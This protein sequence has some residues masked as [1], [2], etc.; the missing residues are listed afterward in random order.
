MAANLKPALSVATLTT[1]QTQ[2]I[3]SFANQLSSEQLLWTSGYLAGLAAKP[4]IA[5]DQG[6]LQP[7]EA[8]V[9][10]TAAQPKTPITVLFGSESGNGEGI[11]QSL[12]DA[13]TAQGGDVTLA[14]MRDYRGAQ[15]KKEH[16]LLVVVSTHGE[17]DPPE[18]AEEFYEFLMGNRAPKLT[19][20][21]YAVL[22]LGDSSYAQFC[23]TGRQVD[24]RLAQLGA[25]RIHDR[26]DCDVDYQEAAEAWQTTLSDHFNTQDSESGAVVQLH[27]ASSS[28]EKHYDRKNPLL[29]DLLV[30]Q[31]ITGRDSNKDVRH[32]E[33]SIEDS[34]LVFEPGDSLGV[35]ATNPQAMVDSVL[36]TTGLDSQST[37]TVDG[38]SLSLQEALI[39]KR[40]LSN[41]SAP[42]L[43]AYAEHSGSHELKDLLNADGET[44]TAFFNSHQVIDVLNQFKSEITPQQLVDCLK[45]LA[46]RLYS[47]ASSQQ[48][49][50]DEVHLTVDVLKFESFGSEHLGVASNFLAQEND[51]DLKIPVYIDKNTK[52]RLPDNPDAP[53]IM[54]G[55]GTGVAP[56]RA[57]LQEREATGAN[58]KNWL[59]FGA[60]HFQS[61]YLYQLEW[62][63]YRKNGLLTHLDSAFSRDQEQKVYVQHLMKQKAAELYQWLESGAYVYV[64]GDATHMAPDVHEAL[65][66]II[67]EFNGG[68]KAAAENYLKDLRKQGRYLKDVY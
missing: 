66:D 43:K 42:F 30:S 65:L 15:L 3:H 5:T 64:C 45:P 63:R 57:F 34:G 54:I 39:G 44:R 27:P 68:D 56:F 9:P 62:L 18:D 12:A 6:F 50:P 46:P 53:V 2:Q 31:K 19:D 52:F 33:L 14:N 37:V 10:Q 41:V 51:S 55:P 17:G 36:Q 25:K 8:P 26:I 49:Y 32:V 16:N 61:D 59:F 7:I 29:A 22:A 35:M 40:E 20:L 24:E 23:E 4:A 1:E 58:G 67:S 13:L 38:E 21:N 11:A 48:A 47:I 60:Q 28:I